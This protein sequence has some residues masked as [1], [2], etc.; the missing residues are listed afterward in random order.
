MRN[1]G[2]GVATFDTDAVG[3][4]N[5]EVTVSDD[6]GG[7]SAFEFPIHVSGCPGDVLWSETFVNGSHSDWANVVLNDASGNVVLMGSTGTPPLRGVLWV[8]YGQFGTFLASGSF[9]VNHD[10]FLND[11]TVDS[12]GNVVMTGSATNPN[13]AWVQV[14]SEDFS[15]VIWQNLSFNA[16][17]TTTRSVAVDASDNVYVTGQAGVNAADDDETTWKSS[18]TGTLVWGV[19]HMNPG[20]DI[21]Y[22]ITVDAAGDVVITGL[23]AGTGTDI[24]VRKRDA[25]TGASIGDVSYDG[26]A[27]DLALGVVTD[28]SG[29]IYVT[30]STDIAGDAHI[31][32]GSWT[33]ALAPIANIAQDPSSG[34]DQGTSIAIDSAG[35][36]VVGERLNNVSAAGVSKWTSALTLVWSTPFDFPGVGDEINDVLVGSNDSIFVVG[37]HGANPTQDIFAARLQP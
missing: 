5:L 19:D 7:S 29:N 12:S 31:F 4:Y 13:D 35:D 8:R 20:E 15:T 28:S 11:A 23:Q 34:Q 25:T 10:D 14:R 22:S 36:L 2:S 6:H 24:F 27:N 1:L 9:N 33:S 18:P 17:P 16:E 37:E 3:D 32:L 30:G 21:A 26:G